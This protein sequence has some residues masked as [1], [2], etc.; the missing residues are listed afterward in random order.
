MRIE[1]ETKKAEAEAK[2][3]EIEAAAQKETE[4]MKSEAQA[5]RDCQDFLAHPVF[6]QGVRLAPWAVWHRSSL[7]GSQQACTCSLRGSVMSVARPIFG[8]GV[9]PPVHV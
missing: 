9:G 3:A 4:K 7:V 1:A 8:G 6:R 2:K 5:E